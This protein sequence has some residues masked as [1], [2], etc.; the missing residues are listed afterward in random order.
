MYPH[1]FWGI[2]WRKIFLHF[3]DLCS[4]IAGKNILLYVDLYREKSFAWH[5]HFALYEFT[6]RKRVAESE[7]KALCTN[8]NTCLIT[9]F[10][11]FNLFL[12]LDNDRLMFRCF[13]NFYQKIRLGLI[14]FYKN[15]TLEILVKMFKIP[16]DLHSFSI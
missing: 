2:T 11:K 13:W 6:W 10:K 9:I 4:F 12:V 14:L 16:V 5:K 3:L 8:S 1:L 15:V 7:W